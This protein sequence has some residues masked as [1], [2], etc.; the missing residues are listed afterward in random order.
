MV[1]GRFEEPLGLCV[2]DGGGQTLVSFGTNEGARG[3]RPVLYSSFCVKTERRTSNIELSTLNIEGG[4]A[5]IRSLGRGRAVRRRDGSAPRGPGVFSSFGRNQALSLSTIHYQLGC[6]VRFAHLRKTEHGQRKTPSLVHFVLSIS[7]IYHL[8]SSLYALVERLI[9]LSI[10]L[11]NPPLLFSM[12]PPTLHI[13]DIHFR[14]GRGILKGITWKVEAGQHWCVLGPN[15]CGKTSLI[16]I[17]TGYD[18]ATSGTIGVDGSTFG[19]DDWSQVR[20]RVGLVASTLTTFLESSEPVLDVIAGGRDAKLNLWQPATAQ[21][22]KEGRALLKRFGCGYLEKSLW[23]VLSQGEKQKVLICRAMMAKFRVLI[24]DEPCAG[25]D[26][27]AREHFLVWLQ[28]LCSRKHA[29]SLVMVTH[30]VEEIL[31]SM[32]HVL[33]LK[34]GQV[35]ASGPKGEVLSSATLSDAYGA[36]VTLRH[37]GERYQLSVE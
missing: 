28:D 6:L 29:P 16:N 32:S 8:C 36:K 13:Q 17:I 37:R 5:G 10:A 14:R 30:H 22:H 1:S 18:S 2:C 11:R 34:D 19:E 4:K 24:L 25:L 20:K 12:L 26:P 9:A 15:G 33:V 7:A 35:L 3:K 27:V 21:L 31:P 23:G